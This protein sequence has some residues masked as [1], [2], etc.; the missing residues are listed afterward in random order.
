MIRFNPHAPPRVKHTISVRTED[1]E[2]GEMYVTYK[3]L[4]KDALDGIAQ[5]RIGLAFSVQGGSQKP[6]EETKEVIMDRLSPEHRQRVTA[7]L[8]DAILDWDVQDEAGNPWP[9]TP[10]NISNLL[11]YQLYFDPLYEGLL[12]ASRGAARK[13]G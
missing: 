1:G 4:K 2:V 6:T 7:T 13:N 12:E 10:E 5:E 8:L 11:Q 3:V 9:A